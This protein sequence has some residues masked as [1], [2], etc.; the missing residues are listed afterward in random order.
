M[1][2]KIIGDSIADLIVKAV[3]AGSSAI[4]GDAQMAT[5]F[6]RVT[7]ASKGVFDI[8]SFRGAAEVET[9]ELR[10]SPT[11]VALDF[12]ALQNQRLLG[13]RAHAVMERKFQ[14]SFSLGSFEIS[15]GNLIP[16]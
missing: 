7:F 9:R 4:V 8:G 11:T 10:G 6:A 14:I 5:D 13:W 1:F 12:A 16:T 15:R 3:N 2:R